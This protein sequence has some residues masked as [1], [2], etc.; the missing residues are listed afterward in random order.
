MGPRRWVTRSNWMFDAGLRLDTWNT[1]VLAGSPSLGGAFGLAAAALFPGLGIN[2][3][4]FALVGMAAVLAG[5]VH[6]PLTATILLFEMTSDYRII[7]PLMFS[8]AV[9]LI[10]SQRL[11]HDSVYMLGLTRHGID[12]RLHQR[13]DSCAGSGRNVEDSR[14]MELLHKGSSHHLMALGRVQV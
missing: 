5:T 7:L 1:S 8:V 10:L 2:P 11:Q 3:T 12:G 4:A 6:A 14:W 9:S 13:C